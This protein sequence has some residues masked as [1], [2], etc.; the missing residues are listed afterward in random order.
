MLQQSRS[1]GEGMGELTYQVEYERQMET[2]NVLAT[3]P[4]LLG[5]VF[6]SSSGDC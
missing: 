2:D 1:G 4:P 6:P 3:P 5:Y